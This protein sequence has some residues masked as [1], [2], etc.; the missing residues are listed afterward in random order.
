MKRKSVM[1]TPNEAMLLEAM[2]YYL[3][4]EIPG[5]EHNPAIL[6]FFAT[7]GHSWVQDD[8]TAW[9]SAFINYIAHVCGVEKSGK[10]NARSWLDVGEDQHKPEKGDIVVL[11]REKRASWKGHVGLYVGEEVGKIHILGGNQ[12]NEVNITAYPS[13]RLLGYKKLSYVGG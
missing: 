2:Q 5:E 6:N 10:L 7:I 9:C 3:L 13:Y 4:Q 1:L 8:E 11:W 12:N